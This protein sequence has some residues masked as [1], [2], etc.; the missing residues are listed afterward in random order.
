MLSLRRLKVNK[1]NQYD[2]Y[3]DSCIKRES[4]QSDRNKF[5]VVSLVCSACLAIFVILPDLIVQAILSWLQIEIATNVNTLIFILQGLNWAILTYA[6]IRYTQA[7]I[8]VERA[9]IY[10]SQLE[11]GLGLTREGDNY[12]KDY[13]V[14]LDFIDFFY[15]KIY[16]LAIIIGVFAKSVFEWLS[17][18]YSVISCLI[19]SLLALFIIALM[20]LYMAFL[21]KI[22]SYYKT[23]QNPHSL[24]GKSSKS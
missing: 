18:N 11:N 4:A 8:Y 22:A 1:D 2:H 15:K 16:P 24:K 20:V 17:P 12:L 21:H 5:F 3:K 14:A 7:S 6:L 23:K 13:P 10:E 19:D 9:Y